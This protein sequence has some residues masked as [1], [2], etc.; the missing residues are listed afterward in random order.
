MA[1]ITR[2]VGASAAGL[3]LLGASVTL[4]TGAGA[5][6]PAPLTGSAPAYAH[7]PAQITF[8]YSI[9]LADPL[10]SAVLTTHQDAALPADLVGVQVDGVA[11]PP[12]QVSRPDSVDI[13]IRTGALPTDRPR[14][15]SPHHHV[16]GHR[17]HRS[18]GGHLVQ[19]DADRCPGR[20]PVH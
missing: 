6:T 5:A 18:R 19:R 20:R 10:T 17:G 7:G 14:R 11:V 4:A 8:S 16:S 3:L 13:A 15:R 1:H 9:T 12:T 2:L